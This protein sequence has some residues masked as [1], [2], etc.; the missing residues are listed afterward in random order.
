[1]ERFPDMIKE[2]ET[3]TRHETDATMQH[4]REG[5]LEKLRNLWDPESDAAKASAAKIATYIRTD[6]TGPRSPSSKTVAGVVLDTTASKPLDAS[7]PQTS[8]SIPTVEKKPKTENPGKQEMAQENALVNFLTSKTG[9]VIMTAGL[10]GLGYWLVKKW[11]N[12]RNPKKSEI[13]PERGSSAVPK[14]A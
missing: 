2:Y 6:R 5:K 8:A 1:M 10:S 13:T 4:F 9:M 12:W 7:K 3:E 11:R 14:I